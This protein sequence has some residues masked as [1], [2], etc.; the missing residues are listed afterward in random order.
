M[1]KNQKMYNIGSIKTKVEGHIS[2]S[3]LMVMA[4]YWHFWVD[5]WRPYRNKQK[6]NIGKSYTGSLFWL[7]AV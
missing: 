1:L 7:I 3:I 6:I 5:K 4:V 2:H